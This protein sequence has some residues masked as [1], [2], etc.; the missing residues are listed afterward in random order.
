M[1]KERDAFIKTMNDHPEVL[2]T[3]AWATLEH[4]GKLS[5]TKATAPDFILGYGREA[6]ATRETEAREVAPQAR[7]ASASERAAAPSGVNPK[8]LEE[9]IRQE[10]RQA[11]DNGW[12][13]SKFKAVN[14]FENQDMIQNSHIFFEEGEAYVTRLIDSIDNAE[15]KEE[16]DAISDKVKSFCGD[17]KFVVEQFETK[18]N[19]NEI[20]KE[21]FRRSSHGS[22]ASM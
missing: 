19:L 2:R 13:L 5:D 12:T 15:S 16:V 14:G 3:I 9:V 10:V 4:T 20:K 7:T 22:E 1:E 6:V 18:D 11:F 17:F 8:E 21:T